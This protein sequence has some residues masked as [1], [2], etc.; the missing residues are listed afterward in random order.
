MFLLF[1]L[2]VVGLDGLGGAVP[3]PGVLTPGSMRI[4]VASHS[5]VAA[6]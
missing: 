4:E 2:G 1:R 6:L 3:V 5:V